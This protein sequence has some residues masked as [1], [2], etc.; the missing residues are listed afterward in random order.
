MKVGQPGMSRFNGYWCALGLA[1]GLLGCGESAP[2]DPQ[3]NPNDGPP[4]GNGDGTCNVP[5]E[6]QEEDV[7]NSDT[8]VG[9]GTPESCTSNAFVDAVALGGVITFDCGPDP[10]VITLDR[11]AKVFN[12]QK[13]DIVIDGGGKVTRLCRA[14]KAYLRH[15]ES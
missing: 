7:S 14:R 11:T 15:R 3:T 13:P 12:D 10:V 1:V 6:A 8:V 4:T 9:D 5:A 2:V